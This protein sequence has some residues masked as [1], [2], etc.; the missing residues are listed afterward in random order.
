[1]LIT[2]CCHV[3]HQSGCWTRGAEKRNLRWC[4]RIYRVFR[5]DEHVHRHSHHGEC[6]AET[7]SM[8]YVERW[9]LGCRYRFMLESEGR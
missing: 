1:M 6:A 7:L 5:R 8:P 2:T 4:R 3:M 9:M